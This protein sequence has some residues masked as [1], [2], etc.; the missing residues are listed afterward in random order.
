MKARQ[1]KAS[2]ATQRNAIKGYSRQRTKWSDL[3]Y[4]SELRWG[5]DEV[6]EWS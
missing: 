1:G 4:E 5:L 6:K 3:N 2:N